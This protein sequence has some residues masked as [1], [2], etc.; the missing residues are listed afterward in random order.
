MDNLR[1]GPLA[2]YPALW[3]VVQVQDVGY[4]SAE[5]KTSSNQNTV[6]CLSLWGEKNKKSVCIFGMVFHNLFILFFFP[7]RKQFLMMTVPCSCSCCSGLLMWRFKTHH[8]LLA[9]A[10]GCAHAPSPSG[11]HTTLGQ[12]IKNL[13]TEVD[14]TLKQGA[15]SILQIRVIARCEVLWRGMNKEKSVQRRSPWSVTKAIKI[16]RSEPPG[17]SA[18]Q[19]WRKQPW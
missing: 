11:E 8:L 6:Q 19:A 17:S 14:A 13:I 4:A 10:G 3:T 18:S 15:C 12:A 2:L 1:E 7:P 9:R 5:N 16:W